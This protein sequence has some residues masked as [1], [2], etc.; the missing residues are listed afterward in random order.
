MIHFVSAKEACLSSRTYHTALADWRSG[1]QKNKLM[2]LGCEYLAA[3]HC[4]NGS[5]QYQFTERRSSPPGTIYHSV[6]CAQMRP[7]ILLEFNFGFLS[8]RQRNLNSE[9]VPIIKQQWIKSAQCDCDGYKGH[10]G[11]PDDPWPGQLGEDYRPSSSGSHPAHDRQAR[12]ARGCLWDTDRY[13][14][15][16][17]MRWMTSQGHCHHHDSLMSNRLLLWAVC[18]PKAID[19]TVH[20]L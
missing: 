11:L 17:W 18:F 20:L 9:S 12:A 6:Y 4:F 2:S 8:K 19:S 7:F 16:G 13:R 5:Q 10:S 3:P 1:Q 14:S 15:M